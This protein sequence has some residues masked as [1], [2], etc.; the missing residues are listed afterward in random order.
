MSLRFVYLFVYFITFVYSQE[1]PAFLY[2]WNDTLAFTTDPHFLS[3]N[4][5]A[6]VLRN[7]ES[8]RLVF[9]TRFNTL[10]S[11]IS[12]GWIRLGGTQGDHNTFVQPESKNSDID[13]T[14]SISAFEDFCF[15]ALQFKLNLTFGLNLLFRNGD[16]WDPTNSQELMKNIK[17]L[18]EVNEQ[19][20]IN[21]ELGN[22][23]DMYFA[24]G[25]VVNESQ[26]RISSLYR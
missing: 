24:Q 11:G 23:P 22:E 21:F 20:R 12:P 8:S 9:D 13:N 7:W 26:V 4:I 17:L 6:S 3:Y 1:K 2:I 5:D 25:F 10:M 16:N 18:N 19:C 15:L 14:Y